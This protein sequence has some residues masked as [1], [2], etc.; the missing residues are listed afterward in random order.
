MKIRSKPEATWLIWLI[1]HDAEA[2]DHLAHLAHPAQ[3]S[4]SDHHCDVSNSYYLTSE[5]A[6][7]WHY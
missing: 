4:S 2:R 5:Y 7:Y 3:S 6:I 1:Q